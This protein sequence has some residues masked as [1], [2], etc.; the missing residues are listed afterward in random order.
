MGL[1]G[2][3]VLGFSPLFFGHHNS[4]P[5]FTFPN[6]L[7]EVETRFALQQCRIK[8]SPM[9]G[10]KVSRQF[11]RR[12]EP[13]RLNETVGVVAR[14]LRLNEAVVAGREHG[15]QTRL[16]RPDEVVEAETGPWRSNEA[17]EAET[18]L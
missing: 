16:L 6:S 2:P 3:S 18:G 11:L 4:P 1:C 14:S 13:T 15:G 9:I 12:A 5:V 8:L 10:H 17:I 7:R